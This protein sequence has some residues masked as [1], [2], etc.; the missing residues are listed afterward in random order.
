MS[1]PNFACDLVVVGAG[2]AGLTAAA[3]AG[4]Q[5]L[6][7]VVLEKEHGTGGTA[8]GSGGY[9][10]TLPSLEIVNSN[11]TDGDPALHEVIFEEFPRLV[12][13]MRGIGATVEGPMDIL[14]GRGYRVDILG[15]LDRCTRA[16]ERLGGMLLRDA[17]VTNLVADSR[18]AV[19]GVHAVQAD[20]GIEI[21]AAWTML[22][23]GGFVA[24]PVLTS[25]FLGPRHTPMRVRASRANTGDGLVLARRIGGASAPSR[26]F[27]GH[28]VGTGI[29]LDDLSRMRSFGL[30]H[31]EHCV[32][33][34]RD[35]ARFVDESRGDHMTVQAEHFVT[36]PSA[37]LIWDERI[38]ADIVMQPWIS[39]S[40]GEDRLE[41][42]A[43]GG[44]RTIRAPG[45]DEL[46]SDLDSWGFKG[47]QAV[48][49]LQA[50][51]AVVTSSDASLDPPRRN[52]R[53]PV[54]VAPFYVVEVSPAITFPYGGLKVDS[55]ARVTAGSGGVVGGLLAAGSDVGGIMGP[56]YTG[57]L[58]TSGSFALRGVSTAVGRVSDHDRAN[59][60]GAGR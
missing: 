8:R 12:D 54:D 58:C 53:V 55:A 44:A 13:A 35:G 11:A 20:D 47:A 21:D 1:V 43:R 27:Y 16:I 39:G 30:Y 3:E 45:L 51:N 33:L 52:H 2:M 5:G 38:Q 37:A 29:P 36:S 4:R 14:T 56:D 7:V 28:L 24:N 57:G 22:C 23:T 9:V 46:A 40:P 49:T 15:Y 42:A 19:T 17:V 41:I 10:W 32:L 6:S 59:S 25:E 50:F 60:A 26:G 31:S 48:T 34:G 18:G